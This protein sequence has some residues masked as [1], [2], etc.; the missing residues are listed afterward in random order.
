MSV[1]SYERGYQQGIEGKPPATP[2]KEGNFFMR[3]IGPAPVWAWVI[4][5]VILAVIVFLWRRNQQNSAQSAAPSTTSDSQ[6]PQFV[7][8]V[9]DNESPPD[10]GNNGPAP[11]TP[12]T[13]TPVG[14]PIPSG[15]HPPIRV[16]LP[17]RPSGNTNP[18]IF[19][20]TYTVKKGQTLAEIAKMFGISRVELAHA[21][22][23]GTGAGLRTGQKLHV[24]K[25]APQGQPNP[26]I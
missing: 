15:F 10:D 5:A 21:N 18:P 16:K 23:L 3:N 7:N 17:P 14:P 22:G 2:R 19:N 12:P 20:S 6:I 13:P 4:G 25:P 24:P 9:Y 1:S 11:S 26:A 8:Q